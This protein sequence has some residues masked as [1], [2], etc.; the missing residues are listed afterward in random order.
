MTATNQS[1][2]PVTERRVP[3]TTLIRPEAKD[4][5]TATR[6]HT[7]VRYD[8][9]VVRA[10]MIVARRHGNELADVLATIREQ[11]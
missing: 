2:P 9:D 1:G 11:Q 6:E 3:I 8:A 7:K 4:W 10:C 5:I